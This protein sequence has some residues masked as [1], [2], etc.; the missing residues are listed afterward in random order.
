[1]P[2]HYRHTTYEQTVLVWPHT[3]THLPELV[4]VLCDRLYFELEEEGE[5]ESTLEFWS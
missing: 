2:I 4:C 1:M 3:Y 5:L